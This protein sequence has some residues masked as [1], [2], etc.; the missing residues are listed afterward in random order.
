MGLRGRVA[1]LSFGLFAL[2]AGGEAWAQVDIERAVRQSDDDDGRHCE[3]IESAD[4]TGSARTTI[5]KCI[6]RLRARVGREDNTTNNLAAMSAA[7]GLG[8]VVSGLTSQAAGTLNAW[9]GVGLLP[10]M[11]DDIQRR[12]RINRLNRDTISLL[13]QLQCRASYLEVSHKQLQEQ[14]GTLS[15]YAETLAEQSDALLGQARLNNPGAGTP[16]YSLKLIAAEGQRVSREAD[17]M[18]SRLQYLP[19][20]NAVRSLETHV[21]NNILGERDDLISDGRSS[22]FSVFRAVLAAPFKATATFIGGT[23]DGAAPT[24][25][26]HIAQTGPGLTVN[27]QF[28]FPD[29]VDAAIAWRPQSAPPSYVTTASADRPGAELIEDLTDRT[30]AQGF[31]VEREFQR[32]VETAEQDGDTCPRRPTL[33]Q[34]ITGTPTKPEGAKPQS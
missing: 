34:P 20:T 5:A 7:G 32:F 12:P 8:V 14:G 2:G 1:A 13:E 3:R 33:T 27:Y 26:S 25:S 24:Y 21:Y 28:E 17:R 23:Q 29:S 31:L 19:S 9:A 10:A 22:P 15:R 11:F 4:R 16:D 30:A 6:Q 18:L